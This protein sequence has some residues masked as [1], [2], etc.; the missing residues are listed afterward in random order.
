MP[1]SDIYSLG[2]VAYECL[3]GRLPFPG[4][5]AVAMALAHVR[6]TPHRCRADV[7]PAGRRAGDADAGQGS[8][9][10]VPE[11]CRAGP[12]GR[13]TSRDGR[14]GVRPA[15][16]VST[17]ATRPGPHQGR[18]AVRA[19]A[20]PAAR[21]PAPVARQGPAATRAQP[22]NPPADVDT[23][24]SGRPAPAPAG[25]RA[26]CDP[27][28]RPEPPARGARPAHRSLAC[29]WRC[30]RSSAGRAGA[31]RGQPGGRCQPRRRPRV[32]AVAPPRHRPARDASPMSGLTSGA[33]VTAFARVTTCP[34]RSPFTHRSDGN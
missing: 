8:R 21:L 29:C 6:D 32:G 12:G 17:P 3:A 7:P 14:D 23:D 34:D 20:V 18:P 9:R 2:V 15:P 19:P 31:R 30:G 22:R 25:P 13:P 26:V 27:A 1:A 4:E 33:D 16:A 5:N 28:C 11:R 10:P 24:P